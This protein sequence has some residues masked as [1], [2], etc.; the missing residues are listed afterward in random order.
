MNFYD[1]SQISNLL[2]PFGYSLTPDSKDADLI[3]LNTCHIRDK[4]VEKTFSELGRIKKNFNYKLT[5][6]VVA[7]AGCVAQAQG[8]E[9][10]KRSPWV[11]IVV[12]PQ[13][14]TD[15]PKLIS[16]ANNLKKQVN[17]EF[18]LI[19][20]FDH[21]NF[22]LVDGNITSLITIQE[23]CDKFCTFCVVPYTRGAEYSR[24]YN[25]IIDEVKKLIELGTKEIIL[26]G[27]NVNAWKG[28][29]SNGVKIGLGGLI[30]QL[31]LINEIKNIRYTTSH[32]LDVDIELLEAHKNNDKLMP[33]LHLP[34]QSGSDKI[35]KKM[36][37]KHTSY[38]YLKIIEKVRKFKPDIAISS[39]FIIGFPGETD[40]DHSDTKEIIK[41]VKFSSSYSFKYSVRPGTTSEDYINNVDERTKQIR[42]F[43]I[44]NLIKKY[45][46]NFN[47]NTVNTKMKILISNINKKEQFTGKSPYNQTFILEDE[48]LKCMELKI[49]DIIS[50]KIVR[51]NQNSIVGKFV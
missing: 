51:A 39:D 7:V 36:N 16:K 48:K 2:K 43:E 31:S 32:P 44:Q 25:S 46:F 12:G 5:K 10:M 8:D 37:R 1:S 29:I 15:L 33:Y 26:L 9:I 6:P 34:I 45:Q 22:D 30:N 17:I 20:K 3:V 41:N 18:P 24:S 27:Q 35:L 19:P 40:E 14:Y 47:L 49:G 42:L 28:Q 13:S 11:D 23:G 50:V 21:L 4:A 38:D